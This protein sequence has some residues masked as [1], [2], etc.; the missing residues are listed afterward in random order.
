MVKTKL[1]LM[2]AALLL[3]ACV[4]SS[5]SNPYYAAGAGSYITSSSVNSSSDAVSIHAI[6]EGELHW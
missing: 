2:T 3:G 5:T 4:Q 6:S 1:A